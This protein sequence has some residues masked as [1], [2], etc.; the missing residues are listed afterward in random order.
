MLL[1]LRVFLT[2][3]GLFKIENEVITYT[4]ITT[5]SFTGCISGFSGITTYHA[6]NQPIRT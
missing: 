5:N 2:E 4:G 1:P 6:E 3:Y